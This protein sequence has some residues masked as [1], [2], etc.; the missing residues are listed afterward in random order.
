MWTEWSDVERENTMSEARS[1]ERQETLLDCPV[2]L[3]IPYQHTE[4]SYACKRHM[5]AA[6]I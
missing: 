1:R 4:M 5:F 2:K 6:E 3:Y